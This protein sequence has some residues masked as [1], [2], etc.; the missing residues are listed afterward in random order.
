MNVRIIITAALCLVFLVS[1]CAPPKRIETPFRITEK[2]PVKEFRRGLWVRAA[3]TASP[4]SI[5][6][7]RRIVDRMKVTD[8]FVQVVVGGYA[9]YR[10]EILPRSQYLSSIAGPEY[11]PLD[12]LIRAFEN[13]PVRIHAWVNTMLNWSLVE[14]PESLNHALYVH[15]EWFI[16]DVHR[17]SMADYTCIRW[18]NARLE[19]LYLDP[20]NAEVRSYLESICGEIVAKYPVEGIH[21]DFIRYPGILWGLPPQDESAVLA[22][23]DASAISWCS[24]H[25]YGISSVYQRWTIWQAWRL[26][27]HRQWVIASIISDINQTVQTQALRDD[28]LLSAAVFANPSLCRYSFGQNWTEWPQD[29]YFPVVM[30]YTPDTALFSDYLEFTTLH[31][32]DALF[33]IG[34]LW[35]EMKQAAPWQENK[36]LR[37]KGAGVCYFDFANLD[38]ML[39][40]PQLS[41]IEPKDESLAIDTTR[42]APV[43]DL[44][45]ALPEKDHVEKG[46][47][48]IAWG[49]DIHFAAFLLSLSLNPVRDLERM[50]ITREEF[51]HFISNDVSAFKYLNDEIFPLGTDLIMP[52]K[53]KVQYAFFSWLEGDSTAVVEKANQAYALENRIVLYPMAGD[54]FIKAVFQAQPLAREILLTRAGIYVFMVEEIDDQY[55]VVSREKI[56]PDT[57]PVYMNWTIKNKAAALLGTNDCLVQDK[58][59]RR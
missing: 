49:E 44:F 36:V 57:L 9:Y 8:I 30:S 59:D 46:R 31:R 29:G 14:P 47:S 13:T 4:D 23:T 45:T 33:G 51:L 24:I 22:G 42:Y 38:T 55:R 28:C 21:L 52:P 26:T 27:R 54:P 16:H 32:P 37:S 56:A 6:R 2:E 58:N 39:K 34:F 50:G 20:K 19:G 18:K 17:R 12:S 25:R 3:S 40:L 1:A 48:L 10:S 53:R 7:I 15:P 41:H 5:S 35:P 43:E 11:D